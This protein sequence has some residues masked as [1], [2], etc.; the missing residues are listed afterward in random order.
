MVV[1]AP[2][3]PDRRSL[4]QLTRDRALLVGMCLEQPRINDKALRH[5]A[6]R[7]QYGPD[8]RFEHA[9]ENLFLTEALVAGA[10]ER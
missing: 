3:S 7:P 5:Q 6:D 10:R 8:H 9:A 1:A 2:T 4:R